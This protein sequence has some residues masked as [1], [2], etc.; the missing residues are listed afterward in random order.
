MRLYLNILLL[1][2][3]G[4]ATVIHGS[5]QEFGLNSQP[6]GAVAQLSNGQACTTPCTLTIA[7]KHGFNVVFSKLGYQSFATTVSSTVDPWPVAGNVL[8][9]GLIGIGVDF[10]DGA[11]NRLDPGS[12]SVALARLKNSVAASPA[13]FTVPMPLAA[14][15]LQYFPR[16][17]DPSCYAASLVAAEY[18]VQSGRLVDVAERGCN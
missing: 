7:R 18:V 4:C 2:L 11:S 14:A 12:L 16:R 3:A 6:A 8:I 17:S 10:V 15:A 9:G 5:K 13:S 1:S